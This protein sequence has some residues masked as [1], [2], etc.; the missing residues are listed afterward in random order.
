[1]TFLGVYFF[2]GVGGEWIGLQNT[3]NELYK[4]TFFL[5]HLFMAILIRII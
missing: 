2:S 1:M 5:M 4:D 3:A